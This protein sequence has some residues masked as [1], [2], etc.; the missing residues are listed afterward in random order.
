MLFK[1][2]YKLQI[3]STYSAVMKSQKNH[4]L[5][6]DAMIVSITKNYLF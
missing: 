6:A 2:D 3:N 5:I 1:R 4:E